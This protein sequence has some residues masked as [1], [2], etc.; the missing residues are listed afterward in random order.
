MRLKN[1]EIPLGFLFAIIFAGTVLGGLF[2]ILIIFG[3][4]VAFL[5]QFFA[6]LSM[7]AIGL[8]IIVWIL[9]DWWVEKKA[10]EYSETN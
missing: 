1:K 9:L 6:M 4:A 7:S 3:E 8:P 10:K 5:Q 2:I